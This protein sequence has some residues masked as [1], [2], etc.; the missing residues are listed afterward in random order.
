MQP[1]Y[2]YRDFRGHLVNLKQE[3]LFDEPYSVM[4]DIFSLGMV[5]LEVSRIPL[6]FTVKGVT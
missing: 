2:D 1:C 6:V 4:A 3:L 5:L